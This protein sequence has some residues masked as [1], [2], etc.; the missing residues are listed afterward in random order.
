MGE[1][2]IRAITNVGLK[3]NKNI[4]GAR[5]TLVVISNTVTKLYDWFQELIEAIKKSAHRQIESQ[6]K[7]EVMKQIAELEAQQVIIDVN[8]KRIAERM[9]DYNEDIQIQKER[10]KLLNDATTRE[11]KKTIENLDSHIYE[12]YHQYYDEKVSNR[13]K[14]QGVTSFFNQQNY[15]KEC[16]RLRR[17]YI[18]GEAKNTC[19]T[20][21]EFI[22][23]RDEFVN[24]LSKYKCRQ[25]ISKPRQLN[26]PFYVTESAGDRDVCFPGNVTMASDELKYNQDNTYHA[27]WSDIIDH[28]REY[29]NEM[30][31]HKITGDEKKK[32]NQIYKDRIFNTLNSY[33]SEDE[34]RIIEDVLDN[35]E[36]EIGEVS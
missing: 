24:S 36:I 34:N 30:N 10:F 23:N 1:F 19:D 13:L 12:I 20:I 7:I 32:L 8:E 4:A 14:N 22:Q 18:E 17:E 28:S 5:E 6:C 26:I 16:E 9:K 15:F 2:D 21:T 3:I 29:L 35:L 11:T 33:I 31:F 27:F 25:Q